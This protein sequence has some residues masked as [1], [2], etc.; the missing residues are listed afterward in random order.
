MTSKAESHEELAEAER[1]GSDMDRRRA[2]LI[3][4]PA[5]LAGRGS[6]H[7]TA[8]ITPSEALRLSAALFVL[9]SSIFLEGE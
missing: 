2:G 5:S 1:L 7:A 4:V 8:W 9:R 3:A 6:I